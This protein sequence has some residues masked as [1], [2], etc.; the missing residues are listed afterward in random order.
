VATCKS[1]GGAIGVWSFSNLPV[2]TV[3]AGTWSFTMYWSGG[4]AGDSS[5]VVV[6]AGVALGASCAGFVATIPNAGTTWTTTFGPAGVNTTSP[7][8]VNTSA[9]QL[10][11]VIPPGGSL[12]LQVDVSQGNGNNVQ[13]VYDGTAGVGD[14]RLVPPSIVVPESLL[15]FAALALLIPVFTGRKRL[16]AFVKARR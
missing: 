5:T 11:L 16:L 15:G 4:V 6:S 3:A 8:T 10:P 7:F 2:Q 12:C 13:A 1:A 9:S 14:T